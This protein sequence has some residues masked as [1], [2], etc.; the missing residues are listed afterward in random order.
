MYFWEYYTNI[1]E[2]YKKKCLK[3][4]PHPPP[5]PEKKTKTIQGTMYHLFVGT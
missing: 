4:F 1:F 5:P 3:R 2:C